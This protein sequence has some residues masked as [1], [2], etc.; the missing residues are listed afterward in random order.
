MIFFDV[1]PT[2]AILVMVVLAVSPSMY[3]RIWRK[4]K[5]QLV[6]WEDTDEYD[7]P[8]SGLLSAILI[9]MGGKNSSDLQAQV[10]QPLIKHISKIE[11]VGDGDQT[12][13]ELSGE[14]CKAHTF[15]NDGYIQ[16]E[17]RTLYGNQYQRTMLA[18]EFGRYLGDLEYMVDLSKWS[19]LKLKVTNTIT[20]TQF[21]TAL[22]KNDIAFMLAEGNAPVPSQYLKTWEFSG[23][24]PNADGQYVNKTLPKRYDYR[25]IMYQL[26]PDLNASTNAAT[27]DPN[28]DSYEFK[29]GFKEM[30]EVLF[31]CRPRDMMRFNARQ[32]GKIRPG[33]KITPSTTLYADM[34][35]GYIENIT[36]APIFQGTGADKEVAQFEDENARF[37][38]Q[39]YAGTSTFVNVHVLG[40]APY[41]TFVVDFD[42]RKKRE[43][44]ISGADKDPIQSEWYGY[45]DDHT[46]RV[47]PTVPRAQGEA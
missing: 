18:V 26:D 39:N 38:K 23:D 11:V 37:Q 24:K 5:D 3:W 47:V 31:D 2:L 14:Q 30:K 9:H 34:I 44:W 46:F 8:E 15:Y 28:G 10:K 20:T 32:F 17:T 13:Y 7:L 1:L 16:P 42:F 45:K 33:M 4:V 27:N 40:L 43:D 21:T 36:F 22:M 29:F 12:L 25:R 6:T 19:D 41:H 35:G